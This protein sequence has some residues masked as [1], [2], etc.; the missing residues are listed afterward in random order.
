[1][2]FISSHFPEVTRDT[3]STEKVLAVASLLQVYVHIY[4]ELEKPELKLIYN[5]L[6][7]CH[8]FPVI[9]TNCTIKGGG[10]RSPLLPHLSL[11]HER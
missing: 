8:T 4:M 2:D 11:L 3:D 7:T 6:H 10:Y 5:L 1:M 9:V